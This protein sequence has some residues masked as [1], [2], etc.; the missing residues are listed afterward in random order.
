MGLRSIEYSALT[1]LEPLQNGIEAANVAG[2]QSVWVPDPNLKAIVGD[3]APKATLV[4]DSLLDFKP[5]LFGLPP[6][7]S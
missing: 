2:M 5:E 4:I 1:L 7:D 6:F 3:Q